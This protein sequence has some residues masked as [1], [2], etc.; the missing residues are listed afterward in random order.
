MEISKS[1]WTLYRNK[2]AGWQEAYMEKLC[3]EYAA[4]LT[5]SS[6]A[7]SGRFWALEQRIRDDKRRPG[8]QVRMNK[9]H[10]LFDLAQLVADDAITFEDLSEFSTELQETVKTI[11]KI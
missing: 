8:V 10:M 7:A 11:V 2:I 9:S 4:A 1:D 6:I 5:D 3:K